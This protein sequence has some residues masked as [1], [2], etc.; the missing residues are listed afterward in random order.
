LIFS[1][2][3]GLRPH[4]PRIESIGGALEAVH[5]GIHAYL[6]HRTR[7]EALGGRR[8]PHAIVDELEPH[9]QES[10]LSTCVMAQFCRTRFTDSAIDLGDDAAA[11][12][13]DLALSRIEA[14][15]SGDATPR[16][17]RERVIVEHLQRIVAQT[18]DTRAA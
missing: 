5:I 7:I 2:P 16:D 18:N 12:L 3:N 13:G 4:A 6:E 1:R 17:E 14:L 10:C 9:F 8:M 11:I 15:R